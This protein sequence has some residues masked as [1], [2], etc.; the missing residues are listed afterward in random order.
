MVFVTEE[1]E[2]TPDADK[3]A[4]EKDAL[5]FPTKIEVDT[6]LTLADKGATYEDV[7]ITWT[8][9]N[10]TIADGKVNVVLGTS[11]VTIKLTATIKA[12]EVTDTKVFEIE[13]AKKAPFQ[14]NYVTTITVGEDGI[15][16]AYK[17]YV[18]DFNKYFDGGINSNKRLTGSSAI[19]VDLFLKLVDG[20]TDEYYLFFKNANGDVKY[21]DVLD[22]TTKP[23]VFNDAPTT[24]W[25]YD[26]TL[27]LYN[28]TILGT[29]NG[30]EEVKYIAA[31]ISNEA[32]ADFRFYFASQT[33]VARAYLVTASCTHEYAGDCDDTCDYCGTTREVNA[34]HASAKA[35]SDT[36]D[37]CGATITPTADHT[38][39]TC[40]ATACSVCGETRTALE[41][42]WDNACDT[43]CNKCPATREITHNYE[44][45]CSETCSVCGAAN[46]SAEAHTYKACE[47]TCPVCGAAN[48][49]AVAHTYGTGCEDVECDVCGATREAIAHSYYGCGETCSNINCSATNPTTEHVDGDDAD[50]VCDNDNCYYELGT[51]GTWVPVDAN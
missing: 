6:T 49:N 34:S 44:K 25:K 31:W 46:P 36:C 12:G 37:A 24:K 7:E 43:Q 23:Y 42:A 50:N 19:G 35:C 8:A 27:G 39:A 11:V 51:D 16:E 29:N 18:P 40:D 14:M 47:A 41:H 21:I 30:V 28:V 26:T 9:E 17:L 13:V 1:E 33:G 3:V 20:T 22:A 38:F 5:T 48:A 2:V 4:A 32:F 45:A 15:S 10:A